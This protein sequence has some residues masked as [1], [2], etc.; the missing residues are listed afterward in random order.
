MSGEVI[1]A[2]AGL[3]TRM[4]EI[5]GGFA[6]ETVQDVEPVLDLTHGLRQVGAVGSSEMRHAASLPMVVVE[7]Y[8]NA[9][10]ITL[11]EFLTDSV[12]VRTMLNDPALKAFR[13]WEGRI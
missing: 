10:G 7:T 3:I 13:I 11:Q 5:D 2:D 8:C 1:S 9:S 6:I 12:H 4:H